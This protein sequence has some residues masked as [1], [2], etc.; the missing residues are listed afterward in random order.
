M[1]RAAQVFRR[2]ASRHRVHGVI[3]VVDLCL[4]L[5]PRVIEQVHNVEVLASVSRDDGS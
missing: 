1:I 4:N 2:P 5:V 3:R